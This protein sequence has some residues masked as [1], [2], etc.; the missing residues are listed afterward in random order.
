M[1]TFPGEDSAAD[2]VLSEKADD[3]DTE[4]KHFM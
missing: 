4:K 1:W 3:E 2:D